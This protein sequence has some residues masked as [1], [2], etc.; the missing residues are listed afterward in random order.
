MCPDGTSR[1][2]SGA[3]QHNNARFADM[4]R[5]MAALLEAQGDNAFRVAAYRNAADMIEAHPRSLREVFESEGLA[6]LED[7][8]ALR[9][10][11]VLSSFFW[12]KLAYGKPPPRDERGGEEENEE[13]RWERVESS[14]AG[15][16]VE[17]GGPLH[18][19]SL[20]GPAMTRA[21]G[22]GGVGR[23]SRCP[24]NGRAR[25]FTV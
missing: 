4:L 9:R 25:Y 5:E 13:V 16:G 3:G 23:G 14:G 6:G 18:P 1:A 20:K 17:Q 11:H 2:S 8:A 10:C 22:T 21:C 12:K 19:L 24:P 7:G 15:A